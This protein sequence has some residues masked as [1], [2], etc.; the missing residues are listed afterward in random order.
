MRRF[1]VLT[2][3]LALVFAVLHSSAALSQNQEQECNQGL[4]RVSVFP[5]AGPTFKKKL[6]L[7]PW[8][9]TPSVEFT[10]TARCVLS[11]TVCGGKTVCYKSEVREIGQGMC[12]DFAALKEELAKRSICCDEESPKCE[13]PTPW[14]DGLSPNPKCKNRQPP[15]TSYDGKGTVFLRMCGWNVFAHRPKDLDPL[16]LDA[17]QAA[18]RDHVRSLVG[19][20]VCCDSFTA[21]AGPGSSCD[22]RFDLDC[23][24]T[25]NA[26]DRSEDER[27]PDISTFAIA[28]GV[29]IK[30]TDPPPPWFQPGNQGFMPPANLCDC[31]WELM[32]GTRT[33]STDGKRP[34]VYQAR[35]RCP[36]TGNERFTRKE[37]P[38]S[39]PCGP[40]EATIKSPFIVPDRQHMNGFNYSFLRTL[41]QDLDSFGGAGLIVAE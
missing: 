34:H 22:P 25:L 39:E 3:A 9:G 4:P 5:Q 18:L 12:D 37:A 13:Q 38:P 10:K 31:K 11:F 2:I 6:K 40:E 8:L 28:A 19:P 16:L 14:F 20:T 27:F 23:D 35:W 26:T 33:C 1:L 15:Q 17:Y 41:R 7:E 30:D 21:S 29:P 24:G 36:S 32:K